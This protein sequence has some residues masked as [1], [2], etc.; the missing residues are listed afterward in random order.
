MDIPCLPIQVD[1]ETGIHL[2]WVEEFT[3]F[4]F[5]AKTGRVAFLIRVKLT[6]KPKMEGIQIKGN[7]L[8][9]FQDLVAFFIFYIYLMQNTFILNNI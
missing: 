4:F 8:R 5:H 1:N 9:D 3:C 7:F 2:N 6:R